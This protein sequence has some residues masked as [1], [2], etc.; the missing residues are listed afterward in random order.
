MFPLY[1]FPITILYFQNST[2][3]QINTILDFFTSL[4]TKKVLIKEIEVQAW[5]GNYK[6][7]LMGSLSNYLFEPLK[8]EENLANP[9]NKNLRWINKKKYYICVHDTGCSAH[10]AREWNSAVVN[11]FIDGETYTASFQYVVGN[12]GIYH[13]I[14]DNIIGYHAGDG[15]EVNYNLYDSGIKYNG[16]LKPKITISKDGYFEIDGIKHFYVV[17]IFYKS[18]PH[19][20]DYRALWISKYIGTVHLKKIW[21]N[22][23]PGLT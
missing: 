18:I 16:N 6:H 21:L 20:I 5:Q 14:P 11:Q 4:N 2:E 3:N 9:S 17:T 1:L 10:S 22:K 7:K 13:N 15:Y 12:D 23:K 19:F 8:I